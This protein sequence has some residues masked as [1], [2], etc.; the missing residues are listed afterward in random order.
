[1]KNLD[2]YIQHIWELQRRKE[3]KKE[4]IPRLL[5]TLCHLKLFDNA[6]LFYIPL[7][8]IPKEE[9]FRENILAIKK[10]KEE[11][12]VG[13]IVTTLYLQKLLGTK[14]YHL[15]IFRELNKKIIVEALRES[16]GKEAIL[17]EKEKNKLKINLNTKYF[18]YLG[19]ICESLL[20]ENL[21][22]TVKDI[23]GK[24]KFEEEYED[25]KFCCLMEIEKKTRSQNLQPPQSK[26]ETINKDIDRAKCIA[27]A[28]FNKN[29]ET[30]RGIFGKAEKDVWVNLILMTSFCFVGPYKL[31]SYCV[32]PA[33]TFLKPE[34]FEESSG[35]IT[36]FFRN[37]NNKINKIKEEDERLAKI[38]SVAWMRENTLLDF[39]ESWYE[40]ALHSAVAAII[41][42]NWA[43]IFAS[44]V[45]LR[46]R[47]ADIRGKKHLLS[48]Y[49][50]MKRE[51]M[52]GELFT[53][54]KE[55]NVAIPEGLLDY[56]VTR[57]EYI[58]DVTGE[59]PPLWGEGYIEYRDENTGEVTGIISEFRKT[60][61]LKKLCE[62]AGG[63][64]KGIE[65]KV[66]NLD[67]R[68]GFPFGTATGRHA[69]YGILENYIRNVS[70][71]GNVNG[72]NLEVTLSKHNDK[73][74]FITVKLTSNSTIAKD[75]RKYKEEAEKIKKHV[76]QPVVDGTGALPSRG[77][78]FRE[79]KIHACLLAGQDILTL[80]EKE[81][82]FFKF[83]FKNA[84]SNGEYCFYFKVRKYNPILLLKNE[85]QVEAF[86]QDPLRFP[87]ADFV[88]LYS[89]LASFYAPQTWEKFPVRLCIL[90]EELLGFSNDWL[91]K[92]VIFVKEDMSKNE[93]NLY[94]KL[95]EK[96]WHL[97]RQY[98]ATSY[99][100][101]IIVDGSESTYISHDDSERYGIAIYHKD[102][103]S[104]SKA[105]EL[106]NDN[107][108]RFS[109]QKCM[110]IWIG[111]VYRG[112][113]RT[114]SEYIVNDEVIKYKWK[115]LLGS[116]VL[117][118]DN[119]LFEQ[120]KN[121]SCKT[122]KELNLLGVKVIPETAKM[123]D[124]LRFQVES[125]EE[126]NL[127][128]FQF[129]SV[130]LGYLEENPDTPLLKEENLQYFPPFIF[131]HTARG[132][133]DKEFVTKHWW[134]KKIISA[135]SFLSSFNEDFG[136]EIKIR[137]MS[138]LL[139]PQQG[140]I[141]L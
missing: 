2:K 140:G 114:S 97:L 53:L 141:R 99:G 1:L 95:W 82:D 111:E 56:I 40:H 15:T 30:I 92:K 84:E 17:W 62:A 108:I 27:I 115:T 96:F 50:Y 9:W 91:W 10:G 130:H 46:F 87:L 49:I 72:E 85:K 106:A 34:K 6:L 109:H 13:Y 105:Q 22:S 86:I 83:D 93:E 44:Q 32:I 21:E 60:G 135:S 69:V 12:A 41:A 116:K 77:W 127:K 20:P 38:I 57:S 16:G 78:G 101:I 128:D 98:H 73:E 136:L 123:K 133:I 8:N 120:Y 110:M 104:E 67:E 63:K 3:E 70:K 64:F 4:Y 119:R 65:I 75:F 61:V 24:L 89:N 134:F 88:V 51:E 137:L 129:I 90:G 131:M 43:H 80:S 124:A 122:Q 107:I 23:V 29:R 66:E 19:Q 33:P 52:P 117:L 74:G 58:A 59:I 132:R 126:I 39:K 100:S 103:V 5:K 25:C 31:D 7:W 42:R 118:V 138:A 71:Y 11:Q 14:S 48:D 54:L 35:G 55:C 81:Q 47:L 121:L 37:E 102:E 36:I 94:R 26:A 139:S 28:I 68:V 79:M 113:Q 76:S 18:N 112:R 125:G 45:L